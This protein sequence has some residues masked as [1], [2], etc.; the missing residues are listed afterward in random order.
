MLDELYQ[1]EDV[2]DVYEEE[3]DQF[4]PHIDPQEQ[5]DLDYDGGLPAYQ[6]NA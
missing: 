3:V 1:D 2:Y 4:F 5:V 6:E